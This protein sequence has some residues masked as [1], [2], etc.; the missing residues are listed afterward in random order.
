MLRLF[1]ED[2]DTD[3]VIMI[4]EIGGT[5]ER[6]ACEFL[7]KA[8]M[9]KPVAGFIAGAAAPPGK[10]MGHAGAI[11]SGRSGSTTAERRGTTSSNSSSAVPTGCTK[12]SCA[13]RTPRPASSS[14][15]SASSSTLLRVIT[16]LVRTE[17]PAVTAFSMPRVVSSKLPGARVSS[18][19]TSA[20]GPWSDGEISVT[21]ASTSLASTSG[22]ASM[23][24]LVC[25]WIL[26]NPSWLA[27]RT[28]GTSFL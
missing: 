10:R 24:P 20:V 11:I 16:L 14:T 22:Y 9:K 2:P 26:E 4:G 17:S 7:V 13:E 1:N 12:A 15:V 6:K 19:C 3:G 27:A 5:A 18:S 23:R 25:S 8:H 28:S 21:P